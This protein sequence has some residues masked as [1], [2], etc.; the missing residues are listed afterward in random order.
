MSVFPRTS[1]VESYFY[2]VKVQK[3]DFRQALT[4]LSLEGSLHSKQ[5][6]ILANH[7][8]FWSGPKGGSVFAPYVN[9]A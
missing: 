5:F 2:I 7:Q 4:D 9:V 3:D 1:Q 8:A 6:Y